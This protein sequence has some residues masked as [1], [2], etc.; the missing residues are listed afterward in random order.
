[1]DRFSVLAV[2]LILITG[3]FAL[4]SDDSP[5]TDENVVSGIAHDINKTESGYVFYVE[6]GNGNN[7]KC[8]ARFEPNDSDICCLSGSWSEDSTI[9]FVSK[10]LN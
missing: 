10:Q 4:F 6:D 8:F 5:D 3:A 1:M 9:F 7:V 2:S